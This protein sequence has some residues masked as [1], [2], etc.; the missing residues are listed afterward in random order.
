MSKVKSE[1]QRSKILNEQYKNN[2]LAVDLPLYYYRFT[3]CQ[4]LVLTLTFLKVGVR[5]LGIEPR[6]CAPETHI[7]PLY[8]TLVLINIT[9]PDTFV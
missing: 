9:L 5:V 8:H 1:N 4:L 2:C 6:S 3:Y 7:I